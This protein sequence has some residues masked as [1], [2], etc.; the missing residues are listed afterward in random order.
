[1]IYWLTGLP[2]AGKTTIALAL[3]DALTARGQRVGVLDGDGI[4]AALSPDLGFTPAER[5]QHIRRMGW[6]ADLLEQ[7]G[8]TVIAIK[9]SGGERRET[10]VA[11]PADTVIAE[12]D[13]LVVIGTDTDIER[14]RCVT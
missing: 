13:V 10:I 14:F 5:N 7:H 8:V 12:G 3:A 11:P 6:L 2:A 9:P 4:R 1:M